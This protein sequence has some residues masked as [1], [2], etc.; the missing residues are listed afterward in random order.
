[1]LIDPDLADSRS[2]IDD[3]VLIARLVG[4]Q[5]RLPR[6]GLFTTSY[7][8]DRACRAA[9]VGGSG[10]LSGPFARLAVDEQV[11]VTRVR[12]E[13]TQR[14]ACPFVPLEPVPI[15]CPSSR[16]LVVTR[17]HWRQLETRC[18]LKLVPLTCTVGKGDRK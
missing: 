18:D 7:W 13:H 4:E 17:G 11:K 6:V 16:L 8:N 12:P 14:A 5:V 2:L 1:M 15:A 3:R 10:Q 9:V